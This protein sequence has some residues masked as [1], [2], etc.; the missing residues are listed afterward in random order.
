VTVLRV[1]VP[2]VLAFIGAFLGA[3]VAYR[4][5]VGKLRAEVATLKNGL[6]L[7]QHEIEM[8]R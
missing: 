2:A 8:L 6:A 5:E 1:L 7:L 3:W 4:K